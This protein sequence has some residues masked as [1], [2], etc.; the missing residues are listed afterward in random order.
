VGLSWINDP[1]AL[2][3]QSTIHR[4]R[5]VTLITRVYEAPARLSS[6]ALTILEHRHYVDK[7][8]AGA[9]DRP[10]QSSP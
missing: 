8:P 2:G 10:Q 1:L 4:Q 5:E 6:L 7:P 9:A 3:R